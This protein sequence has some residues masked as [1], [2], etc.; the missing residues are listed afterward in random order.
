MN[1]Y[2]LQDDT[3]SL[4]YRCIRVLM[5]LTINTDHFPEDH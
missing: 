5:I 2:I 4:Q 1:I 3:R